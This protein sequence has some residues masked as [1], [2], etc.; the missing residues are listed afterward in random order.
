VQFQLDGVS[1]GAEV[2]TPPYQVSWN[3]TSATNGSHSLT[4]RARDAAGNSTV[5]TGVTVTVSNGAP[6][7]SNGLVAAYGFNEGGGT[8]VQDASGNRNNGTISGAQWVSGG[9]YGSALSFNGSNSIVTVADSATL[10]LTTSL[11]LEAWLKPTNPPASWQAV[12]FKEMPTDGAYYLYRSGYTAQPIGGVFT[13]GEGNV[14]APSGLTVNSWTHL[15]FT[16]DGV[17]ERLYINGVLATSRAQTGN[18]QTSTGVLHIGGDNVWG[19]HYQG[20]IDELR[21]YNRALS[22]SE[23]QTDMNAPIVP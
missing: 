22:V 5:S 19:E 7:P 4:A 13:N 1:L 21:I 12:V 11:T 2:T 20:L 10:D 6:P 18:V 23:I 14:V 8:T 17:T 9:R 15:A 3:T 16:Y